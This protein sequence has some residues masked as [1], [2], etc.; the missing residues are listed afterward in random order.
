MAHAVESNMADLYLTHLKEMRNCGGDQLTCGLT[1]GVVQDFL[2]EGYSELMLAIERGYEVFLKLQQSHA[3]FL[4]LDESQQIDEAH[5]GLTNFYADDA[6]NPYVAAGASGPWIVSLKGAVIYDVGGYGMLGLGHAP[7]VVL[8]AMNQPHVMANI[9]TAS[10]SQLEF[11][12][13]LRKEIGHTRAGGTP[14][15]S[16]LCLN[17]GSEAMSLASRL[18][19]INTRTLTDPGARHEGSKI[20]GLTLKGSFHGRTDRPARFSDSCVEQYKKYLASYRDSDYL[21]TVEPNDIEALEAVYAK[22]QS[23][24]V[25]IEAFFMEPVMGEGNPGMPIEPAFYSRARELTREHGTVFVIDSIQAGLRTTGVLSIVD[26]PGFEELDAPDVE[27]YSKALNAGQYP[28]SVLALSEAVTSTYRHG[29]YGNT[30]TSNP[31]ALDIAVS[32]LDSLNDTRRE[33][34]RARGKELV[35]GMT[36]LVDETDGAVTSAQ[37]TGLLLSCALAPRF[38][39]YGKDSTEDYL[40]R[41][42][43]GVIHGGE[44]SLR[45]TPIFDITGKE[46]ALILQLT[47][48][49]LLNGPGSK[50]L[51]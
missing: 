22:A 14:Y 25:F 49:A 29:L 32:V 21:I 17:S 35:D 27:S 1:D 23:D 44:R 24:G 18:A 28:L 39:T 40:R 19:D 34:I 48:D 3:G 31:R 51:Q 47:K 26:Y 45:Y 30:M 16:F 33:N 42:G 20:C 15:A 5:D 38:K 46:V 13:R 2:D 9:M 4:A 11:V 37:G 7:S 36:A 8:E 12:K 41:N 50:A 10:V 6:I 43:L